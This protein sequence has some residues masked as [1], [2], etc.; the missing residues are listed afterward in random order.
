MNI[1]AFKALQKLIVEKRRLEAELR[2]VNSAITKLEEVALDEMANN[3]INSISIEG[4]NLYIYKMS[5]VAL[6]GDID[7]NQVALNLKA[8]GLGSYVTENF[9]LNSISA[10]YRESM[11]E[12]VP[13]LKINDKFR[14]G[15]K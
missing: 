7:R 3:G 13:G 14:I 2:V 1:E 12:P 6:S 8:A 15:M 9:N 5:N 11:E 10:Y 4:N